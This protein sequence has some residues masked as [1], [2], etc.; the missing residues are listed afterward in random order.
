LVLGVTVFAFVNKIMQ[1]DN[2]ST[3]LRVTRRLAAQCTIDQI[4]GSNSASANF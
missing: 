1:H 4:P 2:N 3:R